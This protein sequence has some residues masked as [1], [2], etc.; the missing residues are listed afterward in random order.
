MSFL[1]I[2]LVVSLVGV[3][4]LFMLFAGRRP[5][6]RG[7]QE[8]W[9][10]IANLIGGTA[11]GRKVTGSYRG[12]AVD[13]SLQNH[14]YETDL[15]YYHQIMKVGIR[16]FDWAVSFGETS[17][18]NPT[19]GWHIKCGD[20]ALRRRLAEAGAFELIEQAPGKPDVR[21]RADKGTLEYSLCVVVDTY[22]PTP[23]EFETQLGLLARLADINE[24][25][26]VW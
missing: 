3:V 23:D 22:V 10:Q 17:F 24:E 6:G 21:Y 16:G 18:L 26:N 1:A 25:L 15:Y 8:A 11:R 5:Q 2:V 7:R 13:V 12:R 19:K 9:A 20:E 4:L 14:G